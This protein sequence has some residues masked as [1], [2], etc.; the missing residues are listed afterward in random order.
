MGRT[1]IIINDN[2]DRSKAANWCQRA[3]E[4]TRIEFRSAKR[5]D[6]QNA[7]MWAMLSEI[8]SQA[9]HCENHYTADEWKVLFMHACGQEVQFLPGLDGKTFVPWGQSSS[10]LSK[11]EMSDL[12]EFIYAWGAENGVQFKDAPTPTDAH[13]ASPSVESAPPSESSLADG[14]APVKAGR[15]KIKETRK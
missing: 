3:P 11:S 6:D 9:T 12:I 10:K 1:L 15:D 5:S 13:A 7:K 8:A 4:G 2:A 14:G